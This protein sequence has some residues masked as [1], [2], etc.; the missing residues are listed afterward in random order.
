MALPRIDR[1]SS[2]S[3]FLDEN[4]A[5]FNAI[6]RF[7]GGAV[8]LHELHSEAWLV[9]ADIEAKRGSAVDFRAPSDQK[10]VVSWV[11]S[12]LK[13]SRRGSV[14]TLSIDRTLHN[15]DDGQRIPW[16][17]L[18]AAPENSDPLVW[19]LAEG[20]EEIDW[21]ALARE[22]YS[23]LSAFILLLVRFSW[24]REELARSLGVS[25]LTLQVRMSRAADLWRVQPSMFDRI[26][27][28]DPNFQA[29]P[30][31]SRPFRMSW[32]GCEAQQILF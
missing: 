28:V 9:A 14:R 13:F 8:A 29:P 5:E 22:T 10:L 20:E 25:L 18:F 26:A 23:E 11:V 31:R 19:I 21:L 6:V 7:S 32:S 24:E 1:H 2:F 3:K 16:L 12:K 27:F 4:A 17:S 30:P 15:G